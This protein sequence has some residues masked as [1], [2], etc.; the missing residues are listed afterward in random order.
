M[1]SPIP[2]SPSRRS[3]LPFRRR[4]HG[5]PTSRSTRTTTPEY[6]TRNAVAA[7]ARCVEHGSEIDDETAALMAANGVAHVPTLVT[8]HELIADPTAAGVPAEMAG[9]V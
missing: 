3:R 7:G 8:I 6:G 9:R 2:S 5:G 4:P 1:R